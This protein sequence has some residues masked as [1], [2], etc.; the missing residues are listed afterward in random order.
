MIIN[1]EEETL[2]H[3]RVSMAMTADGKTADEDGEWFPLCPYERQRIYSHMSWSDAII[4][5]AETVMNTDISFM[6]PGSFGRPIRAVIDPSL[7]TDPSKKIYTSRKGSVIVFTSEKSY[8]EKADRVESLKKV[9]AEVVPLKESEEGGRIAVEEILAFLKKNGAEK[10]L[11]LGGGRTNYY[12]FRNNLVDEYYIT[13]SPILLGESK[14]TPISGGSFPFPG[15]KLKLV[16]W[17]ICECGEEVVLKYAPLR[18]P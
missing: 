9:G 14:Y 17:K 13:I 10:I 18:R 5:G 11:V 1:C 8:S 12:F 2:M 6:P 15:I 3:V 16:E 4:V 7:R